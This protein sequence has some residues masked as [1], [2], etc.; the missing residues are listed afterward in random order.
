[1]NAPALAAAVEQLAAEFSARFPTQLPTDVRIIGREA[2]YPVV[3]G[4]GEAA[5]VRRLWPALLADG[6]LRPEY[7]SGNPNLV[8]AA[9]GEDYGYALEV[10]VGTVEIN[11]RPCI[12]LFTLQSIHERAVERLV[13]A[14]GR[15]GYGV[16]GYGIQP[17]TPPSLSLMSP[18]QRYQS[19][20]RA[21]G[22]AWLWY[23]VTASDQIQIDITRDEMVFMLNL[24]NLITPVII[25]LCANSPVYDNRGSPFC[26]GREGE[27]ARILTQENRHG[28]LARPITDVVDFVWTMS[29][30]THLIL[31]TE[32]EVIPSSRPFT[33]YLLEEGPDLDAF[34]FHEHYIW[35]SARLRAAYGT[36][37]IRPACQQ[38]W[39]EHMAAM[40]LSLGLV[41]AAPA[42]SAY[43]QDELG[44]DHWNIMRDYHQVAIAHGLAAPQPAPDFLPRLVDLAHDGLQRR[45]H[46][47][48]T[49][50]A[51]LRDRLDRQHDPAQRARQIFAIDGLHGLLR[52][53]WIRP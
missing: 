30:P 21:M 24:G 46:G 5:D 53:A 33:E 34:L 40:A 14:A 26:S 39:S 3:T 49:L 23:T 22:A 47:E 48:E 15:V 11:T 29:E 36:L 44:P 52:H 19:L 32:G 10:G 16:L 4:T 35:N 43:I 45:G 28:M 6:E 17:V 51:P 2:E 31:K 27:M 7:D 9:R 1:V 13:R 18:K 50:L 37:E 12:D 42:I 20:Y 41:E 38:P 8:V 25:A